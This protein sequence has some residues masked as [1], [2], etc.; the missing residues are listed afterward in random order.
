MWKYP[1]KLLWRCS[2]L[3]DSLHR[4]ESSDVES[5]GIYIHL[6]FCLKKCNY[7]DFLSFLLPSQDR[8]ADYVLGLKKE[9]QLAAPELE[10]LS[11][12]SLYLGGGTPSLLAS[13][14]LKDI[15]FAAKNYF[16]LAPNAEV[17]VEANPG[18][19]SMVKLREMRDMGV[20]RLSLGVQSMNNRLLTAMGR[21]HT[22]EEARTCYYLG[23]E[24]GFENINVDL[25][26]GLPGQ[27]KEMWQ[28]TLVN[29]AALIPEHVSAYGLSLEEG[30]PWG[31]LYSQDRLSLPGEDHW[32][33]MH[34]I[35]GEIL[36]TAGLEQYE[37]SNYARP[38][39]ESVHN[40]GYW[41]RRPY[42]G[43]GLGAASL[44]NETR[45]RNHSSLEKY[46]QD[47]ASNKLPREDEDRLSVEEAMSETMFLGLR[48]TQGISVGEFAAKYSRLPEEI[49]PD[50]IPLI[51]GGVLFMEEGRLKLDSHYYAVSNEVFARFV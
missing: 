5:F 10:G 32:A 16:S 28:D 42:I 11:A 22:A 30:T 6:P 38:G 36:T 29:V 37:I 18:T 12:A 46:F 49:F 23:R 48:T 51:E 21:V 2:V 7:C 45:Y 44:L 35:T 25:I 8:V 24:A 40:L 31:D 20:N 47:L 9:M 17:T 19:L 26:Y 4:P 33:A 43:L 13:R 3:T 27:T 41:H 1:R 14:N 34:D 39:C 50:V 15:L